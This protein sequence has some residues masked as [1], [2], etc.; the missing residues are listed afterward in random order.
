MEAD[1]QEMR[2]AEFG[3][4]QLLA[5]GP[6]S[7]QQSPEAGRG[8]GGFPCSFGA[9]LALPAPRL[10]T[11]ENFMAPDCE[12]CVSVVFTPLSL[13]SFVSAAARNE[14]TGVATVLSR[15]SRPGTGHVLVTQGSSCP[16]STWW[17]GVGVMQTSSCFPASAMLLTFKE[18][19]VTTEDPGS[20]PC[21][22]V[23]LHTRSP[24]PHCGSYF[25]LLLA[26]CSFS[27]L[28]IAWFSPS[29]CVLSPVP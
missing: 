26:M 6:Q 5:R 28:V 25:L 17:G 15:T 24:P 13:W 10:Q 22:C 14:C 18:Q 29:L 21:I 11:F 9:R 23:C 1:T 4:L 8:Q 12:Q 27:K 16:P 2:K 7:C 3:A 20:V 19:G